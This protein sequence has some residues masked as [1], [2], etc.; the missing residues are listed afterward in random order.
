MAGTRAR[1]AASLVGVNRNTSAYY[2][3][4]L[5]EII[6]YYLEQEANILNRKPIWFSVARLKWMNHILAASGKAN[7]DAAP[8]R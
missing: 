1:C 8:A 3:H 7:E 5:R 6:A 2:F 4:R